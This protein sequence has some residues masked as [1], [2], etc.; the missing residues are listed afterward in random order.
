MKKHIIILLVA[1]IPFAGKAQI[2]FASFLEAG[3]ADAEKLL[4]GY[5][6]PAFLGF[7]YGINSGWYNTAKPHKL[8]GFDITPTVSFAFVPSKAEFFSIDDSEFTNLSVIGTID[9]SGNV[10]SRITE[11]PTLFGPNLPNEGLPLLQ[12]TSDN[13]TPGDT[14]DDTQISISAPTGLGLDEAIG[15]SAV[16]S[17]MVQVGIGLFKNTE[18]KLRIIPK[19]EATNDQGQSEFEFE[20]FGIGF[21]HVHFCWRI[22]GSQHIRSS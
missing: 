3:A 9:A 5:L 13:G 6:R 18:L 15:L 19:I 8:L 12:Y 10:G 11:S 1:I 22:S 17:G 7:G 14:S 21:M 4:E 16:P 20:M 2:D